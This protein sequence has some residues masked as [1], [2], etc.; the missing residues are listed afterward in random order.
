MNNQDVMSE[1]DYVQAQQ[2]FLADI[3]RDL[4]SIGVQPISDIFHLTWEQWLE[5]SRRF[6]TQPDKRGHAT[7]AKR[8]GIGIRDGEL[9]KPLLIK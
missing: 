1:K 6:Y 7:L 9:K 5:V 8:F 3:N 4:P 2:E